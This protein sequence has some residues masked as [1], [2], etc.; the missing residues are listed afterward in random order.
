M[1]TL[2]EKYKNEI[3]PK[4]QEEFS[5]KNALALPK[6]EKIVINSSVA[7]AITNES[8]LEKVKEQ[9]A[10]ISG[11]KPKITKAKKSISSFKLKEGDR[12]GVM[13]TLR[14][15]KAWDFLEKLIGIVM[16][17][18]R[19]FRGL[20]QSSF[21]KFGNL[22]LGISEQIIFPEID[23]SKIDKTRG[24]VVTLVFKNSSFEKSKKTLELLG[25]PF[26]S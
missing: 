3:I 23:Y 4:L 20:P 13:V 22:N 19:D 14:G 24:L 11:Q 26:K 9:L 7:E 25:A 21:D 8:I 1:N 15:K 2:F 6:L 5:I 10:A 18:I 16:P 12:I 17:R